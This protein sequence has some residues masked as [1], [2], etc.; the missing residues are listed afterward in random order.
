MRG[1]GTGWAG[2]GNVNEVYG[3]CLLPSTLCQEIAKT[4]ST[5]VLMLKLSIVGS[6]D[7]NQSDTLLVCNIVSLRPSRL[8]RHG[9]TFPHPLNV[10]RAV[11]ATRMSLDPD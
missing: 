4:S 6:L 2:R 11:V 7:D 8:Q 5:Y 3:S 9:L 1:G 10:K